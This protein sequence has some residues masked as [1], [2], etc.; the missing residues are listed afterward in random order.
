V[1]DISEPETLQEARA[2]GRLLETVAPL[3]K[4]IDLMQR[5]IETYRNLDQTHRDLNSTPGLVV[6][7]RSYDN[8][9][10]ATVLNFDP[11]TN[12]TVSFRDQRLKR[13]EKTTMD[14]ENKRVEVEGYSSRR[15]RSYLPGEDFEMIVDWNRSVES[16]PELNRQENLTVKADKNGQVFYSPGL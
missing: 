11:E 5:E 2:Y 10:H 1:P 4:R 12:Q 8:T 9:E 3:N 13:L 15:V 7:H 16:H 14:I 6:V